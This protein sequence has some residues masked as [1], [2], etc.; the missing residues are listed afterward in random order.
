MTHDGA[1]IARAVL[2]R[3][4]AGVAA[5]DL[6]A[7]RAAFTDDAVLIGT[8]RANFTRD[9]VED[10]LDLVAGAG[11]LRWTIERWHVVSDSD[12]HVLITG[13]SQVENAGDDGFES[14][15]FRLTMAL[16]LDADEWRI[17]HFH[18]S[19]PEA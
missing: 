6:P 10:Y 15:D 8:A 9:E 3:L 14:S 2:D 12:D 1:A 5:G 7:L 4:E 19:V 16:V 11:A 18:G 17:E 13:S